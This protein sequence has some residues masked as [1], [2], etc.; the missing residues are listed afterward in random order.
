MGRET[1]DK[2]AICA[3]RIFGHIFGEEFNRI[4]QSAEYKPSSYDWYKNVLPSWAKGPSISRKYLP[5]H[6]TWIHVFLA[7]YY[8]SH[9]QLAL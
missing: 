7:S 2:Y 6:Q 5:Y 3:V 1:E 8:P 9:L 4:I